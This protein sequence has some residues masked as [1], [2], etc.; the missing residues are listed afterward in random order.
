MALD[1]FLRWLQMIT[2]THRVM[3]NL[4]RNVHITPQNIVA[5]QLMKSPLSTNKY[6][7]FENRTFC[8]FLNRINICVLLQNIL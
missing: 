5:N 1:C 8:D 6:V 4:S 7:D 3:K 2:T